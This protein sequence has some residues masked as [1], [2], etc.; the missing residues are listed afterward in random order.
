MK[1]VVVEIDGM[2]CGGCVQRATDVL[3]KIP[4]VRVDQVEVGRAQ[5]TCLDESA[6]PQAVVDA[7]IK[8]GSPARIVN[9]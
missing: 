9:G 2:R 6:S 7:L 4:G 3:K 8:A 5:V 1:Q